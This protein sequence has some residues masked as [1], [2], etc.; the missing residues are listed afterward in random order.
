MSSPPYHREVAAP[1]SL[2]AMSTRDASSVIRR[3]EHLPRSAA[4][5]EDS[6]NV[7]SLYLADV[8]AMTG[9]LGERLQDLA[10]RLVAI[11]DR[12]SSFRGTMH[13]WN[14]GP[15]LKLAREAGGHMLF[16]D[17]SVHQCGASRVSTLS[18]ASMAS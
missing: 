13:A 10:E 15:K 8:A 7:R 14:E 16:L 9:P 4:W 6:M 17:V 18:R 12:L 2:V 11:H 5:A 3:R 1:L